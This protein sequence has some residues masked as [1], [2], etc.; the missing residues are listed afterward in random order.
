MHWSCK[1]YAWIMYGIRREY[2][3]NLYG[4]C[5][6]HAWTTPGICM[7]FV[8][9][10]HGVCAGLVGDLFGIGRE[11]AWNV[12]GYIFYTY[13]MHIPCTFHS[14]PTRIPYIFITLINIT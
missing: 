7:E 4:I 13:S 2:G 8:W 1:E 12:Y 5:T 14:H 3:W 9:A 6:E 10:V 11:Y